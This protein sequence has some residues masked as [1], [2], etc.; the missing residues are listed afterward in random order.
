MIPMETAFLGSLQAIL[1]EA[2]AL[3]RTTEVKLGRKQGYGFDLRLR[4]ELYYALYQY[5]F[6]QNEWVERTFQSHRL[7]DSQRGDERV[8]VNADGFKFL[9]KRRT[10]KLVDLEGVDNYAK[11]DWLLSVY[12]TEVKDP[13]RLSNQYPTNMY[14]SHV[15][16]YDVEEVVLRYGE[17]FSVVFQKTTNQELRVHYS[18]KVVFGTGP[19]NEEDAQTQLRVPDAECVT[20]ILL[21]MAQ[22][23]LA[24]DSGVAL[25]APCFG[26]IARGA[27]VEL[28]RCRDG[29]FMPYKLV[30]VLS[31]VR[32]ST[33]D[34]VAP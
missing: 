31:S 25:D 11:C 34:E 10:I 3:H 13:L 32:S 18:T 16:K 6:Y 24:V 28:Q 2:C 9:E 1:Q 5:L 20:R 14:G 4:E 26:N 22:L 7:Y 12:D 17:A 8:R 29:A 21:Q 33:V 15:R 19:P 27:E 30:E 23:C